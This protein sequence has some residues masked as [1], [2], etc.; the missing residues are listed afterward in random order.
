LE[1]SGF[2]SKSAPLTKAYKEDLEKKIFTF[3][4][5]TKTRKTVF[6]TLITTYGMKENVH[7]LGFIQNTITMNDLFTI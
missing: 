4:E 7:S 1:E 6:P 3:K 2:I 5:E